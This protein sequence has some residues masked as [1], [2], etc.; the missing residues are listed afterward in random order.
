MPSFE[1]PAGEGMGPGP[2]E[3]LGG[4][5][6]GLGWTLWARRVACWEGRPIHSLANE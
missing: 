6:L 3:V 1:C 5:L 2:P 4:A